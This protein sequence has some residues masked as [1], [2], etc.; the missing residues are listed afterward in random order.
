LQNPFVSADKVL[1]Y[2]G[3]CVPDACSEKNLTEIFDYFNKNIS[4]NC[5]Q[6]YKEWN[7]ADASAL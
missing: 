4:I 7:S 3:A 1:L 2:I 5:L 6:Q